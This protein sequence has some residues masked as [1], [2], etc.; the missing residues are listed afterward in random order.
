MRFLAQSPRLLRDLV[1]A[2]AS[3]AGAQHSGAPAC[4]WMVAEGGDRAGP[5]AVVGNLTSGPDFLGGE[6]AFSPFVR[7][8]RHHA[9]GDHDEDRSDFEYG[10][11]DQEVHGVQ[12][13]SHD[14]VR[15]TA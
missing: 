11:D 9:Q 10:E 5:P 3:I 15:E 13:K 2:L 14:D 4:N 7:A 12:K 1:A 8:P 6:R